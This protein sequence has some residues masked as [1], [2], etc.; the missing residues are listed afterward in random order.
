[1]IGSALDWPVEENYTDCTSCARNHP[2]NSPMGHVVSGLIGPDCMIA[3]FLK[4]IAGLIPVAGHNI[5]LVSESQRDEVATSV[6]AI[7]SSLIGMIVVNM[8]THDAPFSWPPRV[9]H[10][11]VRSSGILYSAFLICGSG[12]S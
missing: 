10:L 2:G 12:P 6:A 7:L 9:N 5:D 8:D 11:P 1:M 3:T 4:V